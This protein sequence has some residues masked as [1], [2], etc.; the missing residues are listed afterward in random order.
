M[1]L[2]FRNKYLERLVIDDMKVGAER[3]DNPTSHHPAWTRIVLGVYSKHGRMPVIFGIPK[4]YEE[5][6]I[7]LGIMQVDSKHDLHL[8]RDNAIVLTQAQVFNLALYGCIDVE[9]GVVQLLN[10][11]LL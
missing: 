6:P 9:D 7:A 4:E 2:I 5:G 3:A 8:T 11:K 10:V 1:S